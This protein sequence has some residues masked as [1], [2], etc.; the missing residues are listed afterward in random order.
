MRIAVWGLVLGVLALPAAA[1]D[2]F[3]GKPSKVSYDDGRVITIIQRHGDD[4][5]YTEPYEGFQ[6]IVR[7]TDMMLFLK[8]VRAGARLTEYRWISRLPKLAQ[9]VAGYHFDIKGTMK[10]GDD[11]ALPYRQVGDVLGQEMMNIGPCPY[12]VA[13][14]K[15]ETFMNNQLIIVSTD[16]LSTDLMVVLRSEF[17][18]IG[19]MQIT[20]TVVAVE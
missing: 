1:Q 17:I 15:M 11:K 14:I 7:K 5:T 10:S 9:M 12:T 16:Y 3:A 18:P 13:K 19:G 6:D 4:V 8:T 2:C 20:R